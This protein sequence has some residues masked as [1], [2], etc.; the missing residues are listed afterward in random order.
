MTEDLTASA[1]YLKTRMVELAQVWAEQQA[2]YP[3]TEQGRALHFGGHM[4]PIPKDHVRLPCGKKQR[5]YGRP[6]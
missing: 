2:D 3:D 6:S 5:F 1:D 4:D